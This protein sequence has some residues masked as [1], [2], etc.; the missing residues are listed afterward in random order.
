M[1]T[2][3]TLPL[4]SKT[5]VTG[6]G[7]VDEA[8]SAGT[9]EIDLKASIISQKFTGDLCAPKTLPLPLGTGSLT[10]EGMKCPIAPGQVSVP[11]GI[12]LASGLP[13]PFQNVELTITATSAKALMC[14]KI[15]TS[16]AGTNTSS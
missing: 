8:V 12:N 11:V 1:G 7:S 15:N 2:P 5:T 9:F 14:L 6:A 10:W 16:P 3:D 13:G 4:G